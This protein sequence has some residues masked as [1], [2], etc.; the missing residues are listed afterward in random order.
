[1]T[2]KYPGET[3]EVQTEWRSI[4]LMQGTFD[5]LSVF[6]YTR[7]L[8]V[9]PGAPIE[10][11]VSDGRKC[12]MATAM[13]LKREKIHINGKDYDTYLVEPDLKHVGGVF[14]RSKNAKIQLWV[15]ADERRVPVKIRSKVAVGHFTGELISVE[16]PVLAAD[17]GQAP[18]ARIQ[19][20][21][22][23]DVRPRLPLGSSPTAL[24][25]PMAGAQTPLPPR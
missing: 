18:D 4:P 1:M 17:G 13:I 25:S 11:P 15:T 12:V 19:Q 10:R 22:S 5:P 3:P 6:Y 16:L 9:G 2:G 8:E 23:S 14:E 24:G 7:Q 20:G 21:G